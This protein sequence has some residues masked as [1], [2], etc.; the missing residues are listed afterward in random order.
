M[1]LLATQISRYSD[2]AV[3]AFK[4][5][6]EDPQDQLSLPQDKAKWW[7]YLMTMITKW[8]TEHSHTKKIMANK[9]IE[10]HAIFKDTRGIRFRELA[11]RIDFQGKT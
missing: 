3:K 4:S 8:M 1:Q 2:D 6:L 7:Y 9:L 10:L 5:K 11:K